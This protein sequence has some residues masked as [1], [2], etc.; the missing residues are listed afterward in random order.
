MSATTLEPKMATPLNTVE[1]QKTVLDYINQ[2]KWAT[3][4]TVREDGAPVLR[5]MGSFAL[6]GVNILFSTR[7]NAAKVRHLAKNK[8]VSFY[9]QHE[10]QNLEVFKNVAVIGRAEEVAEG[11][12]YQRAVEILSARNPRFKGRAERGELGDTAIYRI[13]TTEIKYLDYSNGVGPAA[14]QEIIL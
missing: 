13:H 7:K 6:N 12:D 1:L 11:A 4:A 5:V 3:L 14:I 9:F 8:N 2:T 10:N